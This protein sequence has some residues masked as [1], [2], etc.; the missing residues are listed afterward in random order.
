[1]AREVRELTS[2]ITAAGLT[3]VDLSTFFVASYDPPYKP[4]GR[5]NEVWF[6][7]RGGLGKEGGGVGG[8]VTDGVAEEGVVGERGGDDLV[9]E[10]AENNNVVDK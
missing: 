9:E 4:L 7:R 8:G 3:D 1:M 10:D 6:V 5:R 2:L